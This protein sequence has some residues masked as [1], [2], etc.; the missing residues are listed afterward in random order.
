MARKLRWTDV[1]DIAIELEERHPEAG[2]DQPSAGIARAQPFSAVIHLD[3][4]GRLPHMSL[5]AGGYGQCDGGI[6]VEAQR[7]IGELPCARRILRQAPDRIRRHPQDVTI[8]L[9]KLDRARTVLATSE[10]IKVRYH[11]Y[12]QVHFPDFLTALAAAPVKQKLFKHPAP[13]T[14]GKATPVL[15][16]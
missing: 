7:T 3:C 15:Q 13:K 12:E 16:A 14:A 1:Q 6:R 10:S 11:T 5:H 2:G 9:A 8:V 4:L